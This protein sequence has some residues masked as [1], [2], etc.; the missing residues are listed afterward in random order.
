MFLYYL[1]NFIFRFLG[2]LILRVTTV[3]TGK[4]L[5]RVYMEY[6]CLYNQMDLLQKEKVPF[7]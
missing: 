6:P 7:F 3:Q 5:V 1:G 2:N 4:I